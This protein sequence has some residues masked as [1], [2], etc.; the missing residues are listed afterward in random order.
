MMVSLTERPSTPAR[1]SDQAVISVSGPSGQGQD[2][3]LAG[4]GDVRRFGA[5]GTPEF[6]FRLRGPSRPPVWLDPVMQQLRMLIALQ[7]DWD[8]YGAPPLDPHVL[9]SAVRLLMRSMREETPAPFLVPL[10]TGGLQLEWHQGGFDIEVEV[11]AS[12][13]YA[14]FVRDRRSGHEW[15]GSVGEDGGPLWR[16]LGELT[17]RSQDAAE[18]T[19]R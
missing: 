4:A 1:L 7:Q 17:E 6:R 9:R 11:L 18:G 14:A 15:E 13:R 10:S 3:T 5:R 19:G 16:F 2:Y 12:H 8:S